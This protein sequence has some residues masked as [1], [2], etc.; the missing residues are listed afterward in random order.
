MKYETFEK[1][2]V[3][4]AGI[5][6]TVF[7]GAAAVYLFFKPGF[8]LLL[9]F[10]IGWGTAMA[11]LPISN[12]LG[13][14][15]RLRKKI[16][17]VILLIVIIG[18]VIFLLSLIFRRLIYEVQRLLEHLTVD[19]EKIRELISVALDFAESITEHIPFLDRLTDGDE[20]F[21]LRERIDRAVSDIISGFVSDLS[22]R[23]PQFIAAV[24]GALPSI[25]LFIIVTLIS[26]FY[27]CVD[28][29]NIHS[30]FKEILPKRL[31]EKLSVVKKHASGAALKYL[32][33]YFLI[34]L[35]TFFELFVGFSVLG[36]DYAL[37]LA[38]VIAV[39]DILPIFGVGGVLLPWAAVLLISGDSYHG[40]GLII[41]YACVTVV[42]Q[43]AEPKIVGGSIGLHPLLT[44]FSIYAGFKLFGFVGMIFGPAAAL[45]LKSV[46]MG[47]R[48]STAKK[49]GPL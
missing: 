24:I 12:K 22:T 41:V 11:V 39:I 35:M 44:L 29:D 13:K 33:A 32:R 5:F 38:A 20:L 31:S 15:S 25:M 17:S 40:I 45:L 48:K 23:I 4:I 34:L 49:D 47:N 28:I 30:A 18:F 9:P 27:F 2:A 36:I 8:S 7:L 1:R 42:R 16:I 3:G 37:L 10:I 26:T 19:S 46:L 43:F 21:Y 6:L 14:G